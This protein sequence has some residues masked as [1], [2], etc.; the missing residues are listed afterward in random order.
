MK[1]KKKRTQVQIHFRAWSRKKYAVF[2][3]LKKIIKVGVLSASYSIL[4]MPGKASAQNTAE[5]N[6]QNASYELE[7]VVVTAERTPVEVQQ[8]T[9]V[10]QV[11]T[12]TD[13]ERAGVQTVNDLL[14][15]V[16]GLDLR[17]R[18][19]LGMQAD[20]SI[21]GG[22]YEQTLILLNGVNINDPQTGHHNLNLPV[23][24][25]SIEKIEILSGPASKTFGPNAFS[26]VINI[27]TGNS[28]PNHIRL[29]TLY[30]QHN[31][32]KISGNISHSTGNFRHFLS[33]GKMAT[34][35]Y[36]K[37]TDFDVLN[38]F[39]QAGYSS[40]AG[41]IS[42]QTGYSPKAF[43]ANSFYSLRYP[44]QFEKTKS[45]FISIKYE[46]RS[47]IKIEPTVYLRKH[48]DHFELNRGTEIPVPYN[49][50]QTYTSGMNLNVW[51]AWKAGKTSIGTDLRN[52][53]ILSNKLGNPL[54]NPI[55]VPGYDSAFYTKKYNR[56]LHSYYVSHAATI[57]KFRITASVMTHSNSDLRQFRCYPG[58]DVAYT[59]YVPIKL[60]AS[61]NRSMR[62]PTFTEMFYTAPDKRGNPSL[63]PEEALTAEGG[64]EYRKDN[65]TFVCRAFRRWGKNNID[66]V[67]SPDSTVFYC[68]NYTALT[69]SGIQTMLTIHRPM[70]GNF[71]NLEKISLAYAFT[72]ADSSH[73]NVISLY[74]LDY[75]KHQA[76]ATADVRVVK[77]LFASVRFTWQQ[78]NGKYTNASGTI[79]NYNPVFLADARMSWQLRMFTFFIE[80]SNLFDVTYYDFGGIRQP[81]IWAKGGL[82]LDIDYR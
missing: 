2:A 24:I 48:N 69:V 71:D 42:L 61:V 72:T 9:R 6:T 33:V 60:F 8:T 5:V 4:V 79:T 39:Y 77:N 11:I 56:F 37:N 25:E 58:I 49:N 34:D 47:K 57:N 27:I 70:T 81:G 54:D 63:R 62:M 23:D 3:S 17:Q 12:R 65:L 74:V 15:Y 18:G 43:G 35:G 66:W 59:P 75:L 14:R 52:E 29:S 21:N 16:S 10:V 41:I 31:L 26:G 51:T 68:K 76:I 38:I 82:R 13:I 7:D 30:G 40:K 78:R 67:K 44:N 50:H 28:K 80:A 55:V 46:S 19:P 20:V 32:Y 22:S 73:S 36:M 53:Y 45:E 64:L 1:Q